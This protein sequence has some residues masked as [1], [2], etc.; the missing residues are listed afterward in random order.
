MRCIHVTVMHQSLQTHEGV[1]TSAGMSF[2]ALIPI[3]AGLLAHF[4]VSGW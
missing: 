1:A 3:K 4:K 2:I